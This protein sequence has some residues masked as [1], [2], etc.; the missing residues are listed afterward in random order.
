MRVATACQL[1]EFAPAG[2]HTVTQGD[3]VCLVLRPYLFCKTR[4]CIG[5]PVLVMHS[6]RVCSSL[7]GLFQ[8]A[9]EVI[10][11][12]RKLPPTQAASESTFHSLCDVKLCSSVSADEGKSERQHVLKRAAFA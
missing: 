1:K 6:L 12:F 3:Q 5:K 9:T 10:A 2:P 11:K 8:Q 7:D 4:A